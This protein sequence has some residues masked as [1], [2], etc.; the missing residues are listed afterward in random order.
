M[1]TLN[2]DAI[3]A[4]LA[5]TYNTTIVLTIGFSMICLHIHAFSASRASSSQCAVWIADRMSHCRE[6]EVAY[7]YLSSGA[8]STLISSSAASCNTSSFLL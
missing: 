4:H 1:D 7:H 5:Y 2:I 6:L 8:A 3:S